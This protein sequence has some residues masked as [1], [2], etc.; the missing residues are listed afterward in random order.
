MWLRTER[1]P[2]FLMMLDRGR[3]GGDGLRDASVRRVLTPNFEEL[4]EKIGCHG[5]LN[6]LAQVL[7]KSR[8]RAIPDFH[9]GAELWDL[10]LVDSDNRAPS[11]SPKGLDCWV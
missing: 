7:I 9:H 1:N 10:H 8:P 3:G 2:S 11:T 4:Q 6:S 5:A